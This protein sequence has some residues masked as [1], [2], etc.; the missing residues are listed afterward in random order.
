MSRALK[1]HL[2]FWIE[3]AEY[4]ASVV[5]LNSDAV[6]TVTNGRVLEGDVI[7]VRLNPRRRL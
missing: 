5:W 2:F 3:R 6:I 7:A 4:R 1:Q